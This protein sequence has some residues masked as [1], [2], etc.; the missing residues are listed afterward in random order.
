MP[1]T[2]DNSIQNNNTET[3]DL[4][5]FQIKITKSNFDG[6][7]AQEIINNLSYL[8]DAMLRSSQGCSTPEKDEAVANFLNQVNEGHISGFFISNTGFDGDPEVTVER[9]RIVRKRKK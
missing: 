3:R 4:G 2:P 5:E 7:G 1:K 8:Q 9:T 6:D